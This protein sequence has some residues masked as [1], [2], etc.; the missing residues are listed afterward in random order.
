MECLPI[1]MHN[2]S[3]VFCYRLNDYQIKGTFFEPNSKCFPT[4]FPSEVAIIFFLQCGKL[5]YIPYYLISHLTLCS[6]SGVGHCGADLGV[7]WLQIGRSW[8][9]ESA[10][11]LTLSRQINGRIRYCLADQSSGRCANES[12]GLV[13][14]TNLSMCNAHN[15][16]IIHFESFYIW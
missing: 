8:E 12:R 14:E 11:M 6:A 10:P 9:R 15:I 1:K 5:L 4:H 3:V 7:F 16:N 13:D 2:Y